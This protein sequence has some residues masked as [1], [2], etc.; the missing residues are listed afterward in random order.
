ML[1]YFRFPTQSVHGVNFAKKEE[2]VMEVNKFA[3]ENGL[4]IVQISSCD[5]CGIFVVFDKVN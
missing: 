3:E 5:D 2:T 1:K 4:K